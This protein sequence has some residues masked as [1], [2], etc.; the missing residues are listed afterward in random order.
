MILGLLQAQKTVHVWEHKQVNPTKFK[1]LQKLI[2]ELGE[3]QALR[4]WD[5]VYFG[6]AQLYMHYQQLT[7]HYLTV[8]TPGGREQVSCRTEYQRMEAERLIAKAKA[9][10]EADAPPTRLSED[11]AY[12]QCKWCRHHA[13]CHQS[14]LPRTGCRTCAHVTP[15]LDEEGGWDCRQ[16]HAR[17]P[18]EYQK[19]GCDQHL[20]HPDLV[21]S[22]AKPVDGNPA[23]NWI[24][25]ETLR[26]G[27]KFRNG[28]AGHGLS[29]DRLRQM[30][31]EGVNELR[32]LEVAPA[33]IDVLQNDPIIAEMTQTFGA[34]VAAVTPLAEAA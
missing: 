4:E 15:M 16:H 20:Y 26:S 21:A 9:I 34:A 19:Q 7:R 8:S 30:T 23:E 5:P 31:I 14:I 25:Y 17:V 33:L 2:L 29:S 22:Y 1:A 10:I 24:E 6:Q 11:P 27:L 3:K 32:A 12:Y 18:L 28:P 13:V